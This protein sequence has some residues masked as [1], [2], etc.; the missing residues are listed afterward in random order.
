MVS[1]GTAEVFVGRKNFIHE[2]TVA[3]TGLMHVRSGNSTVPPRS[4]YTS[5]NVST[6][7][8]ALHGL[9]EIRKFNSRLFRSFIIIFLLPLRISV[10]V[11]FS[12]LLN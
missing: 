1:E 9:N 7:E 2:V 5:S 6:V 8:A 12:F 4:H 11:C 3:G 10:S